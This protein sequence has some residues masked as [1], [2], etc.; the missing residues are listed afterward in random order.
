MPEDLKYQVIDNAHKAVAHMGIDKTLSKLKE[1]YYFPKMRM[2]V[3]KF[4][5]RCI[6]CLHYKLP[7]GKQPNNGYLHP[8]EKGSTPFQCI[9][10]D[11]LGPFIP[12]KRKMK[13]V[14]VMID[15]FS[16]YM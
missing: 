9:H 6:N 1:C 16:K 10:V 7:R 14:L 2:E 4:V 15:G 13:Y 12:T 11:H 3:T 5:N 8:L